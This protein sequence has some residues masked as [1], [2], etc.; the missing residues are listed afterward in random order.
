MVSENLKKN[1]FKNTRKN[2][3]TGI[4]RVEKVEKNRI[5]F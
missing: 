2:Q 3:F 1:R 4:Y 5:F